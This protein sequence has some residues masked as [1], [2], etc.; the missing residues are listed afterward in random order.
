[1]LDGQLGVHTNDAV[2]LCERASV[3]ACV[4]SGVNTYVNISL[5]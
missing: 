1:M 5:T 4:N 3:I 2:Y